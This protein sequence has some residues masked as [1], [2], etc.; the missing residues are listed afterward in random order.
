MFGSSAKRRLL[1]LLNYVH[2]LGQ[3]N[4][5]P[6][7]SLAELNQFRCEQNRL[8]DGKG[9]EFDLRDDDD[10]PIW[11][12]IPRL[13]RS[14]APD[15]PEDIADWVSVS[16]DPHQAVVIK[17]SILKTLPEQES[18][19]L[20]DKGLVEQQDIQQSFQ[21]TQRQLVL[22]EVTLRLESL[23]DTKARIDEYVNGAWHQW[24]NKEKAIRHTIKIY[25]AFFT[26]QQSLE[27][28]SDEMALELVWGMGITRWRC[29]DRDI[30]YPLIEKLV[31][32]ELDS[33]TG[34]ILIRPRNSER[35]LAIA[36]YFAMDN[37]GIEA[38]VRFD[39]QYFEQQTQE[40]EYSPFDK[41]SYEGLLRQAATQL[42]ESGVYWPDIATTE[43]SQLPPIND[44][45]LVSDHWV[46][47]ARPRAAIP[48]IQDIERFKAQMEELDENDLPAPTRRL[49]EPLSNKKSF[50]GLGDRPEQDG[51]VPGQEPQELFF[52]KP[53]NDAQIRIVDRLQ[54]N[55]GVVVQGPPGTGK[56]HTIANIICHYLATGRSVLVTSS[57]ESALS[58]LREQIPETVRDLTISLLTNER[59]GLKQLEIAVHLLATIASQTDVDQLLHDTGHYTELVAQLKQQLV[60][61][62]RQILNSGFAQLDPIDPNLVEQSQTAMNLA[63]QVMQ[64]QSQHEWFPDALGFEES[65][66]PQFEN[67]DIK[68]LREARKRIGPYL[69]YRDV[70]LAP[71]S[72]IPE[73]EQMAAIHNDLVTIEKLNGLVQTENLPVLDLDAPNCMDRAVEL[74]SVLNEYLQ[75]VDKIK[76]ERWAYKLLQHWAQHG[77]GR[78]SMQLL[79]D[80]FP[81]LDK[82]IEYRGIF[83]KN[84]IHLPNPG[85]KRKQ[86]DLALQNLAS[87]KRAFGLISV[88]Q[89]DAKAIVAQ[90]EVNGETPRSPRQWQ[91]VES[92]LSYQDDA[93]RF[94]VK[95]NSVGEDYDLPELDYQFGGNLK[96]LKKIHQQLNQIKEMALEQWGPLQA[97]LDDLFPT[98]L[99]SYQVIKNGS[100][101]K[102]ALAALA[103]HTSRISLSAQRKRLGHIQKTLGKY[104]GELFTKFKDIAK[105][106]VGHTSYS[107]EDIELE[108]KE[109]LSELKHL[110]ALQ[111]NFKELERV[112]ALIEQSGAGKWA[113]LLLSQPLAS[114]SDP[115][116]PEHWKQS[117]QWKRQLA[118]LTH[119][120]QHHQLKKLAKQRR[121][122]ELQLNQAFGEL[123][124]LKTNVGLHS[125][126]TESVHGALVRFVSAI[127]KLGKGTGKKRAPR[128]RREAYEAMQECF[129][130]VPCWIMP[131]WR[132][133]ESLPA[134]L[135]SFDL[136]IIDEASQSD[137]SA[138]PAI[139]RAKK[140]LVVGDDKQVSPTAAFV[141]EDKIQ[142][143]KQ[144]YLKG[145][146]FADL[147]IPGVSLYD[148][149]SAV[150]PIQRIMLTEHFRCVEPIIR[151]SMQFYNN[152]LLPLRLPKASEKIDPPLVDVYVRHGKRDEQ[153]GINIAEIYAIVDEIKRLTVNPKFIGRSIGVISLIGSEQALAIQDALLQ[154]LGED[155]YQRF[156]IACGDSATFQGK[157]RDIIFLSMVVGPRQ[158][159][160]LNKREY[161]QRFNVALSRARDRMYLFRS[162]SDA[163][164]KNSNDLRAQVLRHFANPMPAKPVAEHAVD[165]CDTAFEKTLYARLSEAGYAAIP[166]VSVGPFSID[167]VV[168]GGRD[169]RLAIELDGDIQQSAEQWETQL[170]KQRV[171]ER[172]GWVFWRCWGSSYTLNPDACFKDLVSTLNSLGIK[173]KD[174]KVE[175]NIYTEYREFEQDLNMEIK[176]PTPEQV[177]SDTLPEE[178]LFLTESR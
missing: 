159:S 122:L 8:Q 150:Y 117:W 97:A 171:L 76:P 73:A 71:L 152:A 6:V 106:Q 124:R 61:I 7:F 78:E 156:N 113:K 172:V 15:I 67:S 81:L 12:R 66:V 157:E 64:Q 165:L 35:Q 174:S 136:V 99:R 90:I 132:I 139:L 130:G 137:I 147:L 93:R 95:W 59:Q 43:Q 83:I 108:W 80:L 32:I 17:Q 107:R 16:Q 2:R 42:H 87:G 24:A 68:A 109:L 131:T 29:N 146:P 144:N 33:K 14:P 9:I 26:L 168:E 126:L 19:K 10:L 161:E 69:S 140:L 105:K 85:N 54:N 127:S 4:Q 23:P 65:Y 169:Q 49:V 173:P 175:K 154:E 1:D 170:N 13:K 44:E 142:Q 25:D 11:M 96:Q 167:L 104:K 153:T 166:K 164:L 77:F 56:T 34:A 48:F 91:L 27:S 74:L 110:H 92:Y 160:V 86:L 145:Q 51:D 151:F 45:L 18:L 100:E 178:S 47:F 84:P 36:P 75:N 129:S 149:A 135:G 143:L 63:E 121:D 57:G 123:V 3:I 5:E 120:D 30:D 88:G 163:D 138:L 141:S 125:N 114:D 53:F 155:I 28:Q 112:S 22:K 177:A 52:P 58:A 39:K 31:E 21:E 115:L 46:I 37:P 98:D 119:I 72:D 60:E 62:D 40:I 20:L 148:L 94:I 102:R 116:L 133:S 79:E 55:Y 38:L 118:Y 101:A 111:P 89:A 134:E 50:L 162:L 176:I 82:L 128:Y 158:G 41:E 103:N 70:E